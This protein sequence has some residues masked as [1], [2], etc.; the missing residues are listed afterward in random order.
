MK[1]TTRRVRTTVTE[2]RSA[3]A[4]DQG[5]ER[6]IDLHINK[7]AVF[8]CNGPLPALINRGRNKKYSN[9]HI[10]CNGAN[11]HCSPNLQKLLS[12]LDICGIT[13]LK[14][15][16]WFWK[17]WAAKIE[18]IYQKDSKTLLGN[19]VDF[20]VA[21]PKF[22]SG[23]EKN[24]TDEREDWIFICKGK[25]TEFLNL[26]IIASISIVHHSL[27]RWEIMYSMIKFKGI[28]TLWLHS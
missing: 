4:W 11:N 18:F 24:L 16:H 5:W 10:S 17:N 23:L 8:K 22:K 28:V 3:V 14:V 9:L 26:M 1:S 21:L 13:W 7:E 25:F 15:S 12:F 27:D 2:I 20:K 19:Q 6:R